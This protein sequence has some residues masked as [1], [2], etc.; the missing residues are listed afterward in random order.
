[1]VGV[2]LASL[3]YWTA[4]VPSSTTDPAGALSA[5]ISELLQRSQARPND[6][7]RVIYGTT[8]ALNVLLERK[9]A[10]VAMVTTKGFKDVVEIGRMLRDE[11]YDIMFD[12]AQA[13]RRPP[14]PL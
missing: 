14:S 6:V 3:H 9:G 1:M 10:T 13:P 11:L 12:K 5:G 8:V 2:D 7:Q 4:K